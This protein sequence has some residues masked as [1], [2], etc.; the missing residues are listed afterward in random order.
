MTK[1]KRLAAILKHNEPKRILNEQKRIQR[2]EAIRGR[3]DTPLEELKL[4][5]KEAAAYCGV[6]G[7]TIKRWL[8]Q[9][10]KNVWTR[11]SKRYRVADLQQFME[12]KNRGDKR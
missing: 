12:A 11:N 10:L 4:T 7:P 8:D 6:S 3:D 5:Q 9:G 2:L 1:N